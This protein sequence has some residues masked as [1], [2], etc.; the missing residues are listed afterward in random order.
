MMVSAINK[1]N[2]KPKAL[3]IN[4]LNR[5]LIKTLWASNYFQF[6]ILCFFGFF[7]EFTVGNERK[8]Y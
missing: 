5:N 8:N 6:D 1:F 7:F 3:F 2:Q 4:F